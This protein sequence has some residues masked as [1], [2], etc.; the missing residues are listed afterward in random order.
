MKHIIRFACSF[1]TFI[2]FGNVFCFRIIF[3]G[4][5]LHKFSENAIKAKIFSLNAS[6]CYYQFCWKSD[7][8]KIC[9]ESLQPV[10]TQRYLHLKFS[11]IKRVNYTNLVSH[12]DLFTM[13]CRLLITRKEILKEAASIKM[14][15]LP[16]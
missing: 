15:F 5:Y 12:E 14:I 13:S 6:S 3:Y 9:I 7:S 8:T 2:Q 1:H 11:H 10:G 4:F 16:I